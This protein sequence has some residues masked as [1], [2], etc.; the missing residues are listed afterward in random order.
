MKTRRRRCSANFRRR[1]S[2]TT[3][4][5]L[6]RMRTKKGTRSGTTATTPTTLPRRCVNRSRIWS[7]M[8]LVMVTFGGGCCRGLHPP[9][10][11]RY[12]RTNCSTIGSLPEH[13]CQHVSRSIGIALRRVCRTEAVVDVIEANISSMAKRNAH[14]LLLA[15]ATA[16]A[17]NGVGHRKC[18]RHVSSKLAECAVA[19]AR[20]CDGSAIPL[21]R[22]L[23]G[24]AA[25]G[26]LT[27][28]RLGIASSLQ[29]HGHDINNS[30]D[31]GHIRSAVRL[32]AR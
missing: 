4:S 20:Q 7:P 2:R 21:L 18:R 28:S 29:S 5:T 26:L 6:L 11:R 17:S 15:V 3:S 8:L 24:D 1:H 30:G 23:L 25:N 32:V 31:G 12:V 22:T 19:M 10:R 16:A 27:W 9:F 13:N 14:P